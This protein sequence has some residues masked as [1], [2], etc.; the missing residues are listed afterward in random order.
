MVVVAVVPFLISGV[1]AAAAR[2]VGH[3]GGSKFLY[4]DD[5]DAKAVIEVTEPNGFFETSPKN[6]VVEFYSPYCV[7][8]AL[9]V[10]LVMEERE[11]NLM[12]A[13]GS[14]CNK[15]ASLYLTRSLLFCCN[16]PRAAVTQ[17]LMYLS[18]RVIAWG[19][20]RNT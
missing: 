8:M 3:S 6:R 19:S 1:T 16:E 12:E 7:R 5:P 15:L 13:Y 14:H 20:K 11:P 18:C 9:S 2:S 10:F 4:Q 17:Y